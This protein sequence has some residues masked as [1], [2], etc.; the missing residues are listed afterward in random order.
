MLA[1][2][3][4]ERGAQK[5][6]RS[7]VLLLGRDDEAA[8]VLAPFDTPESLYALSSFMIYPKFD[9]R[10]YPVLLAHLARQGIRP[11][12]VTP[13]PYNCPPGSTSP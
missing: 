2:Y 11:R 1:W 13:E 8:R 7:E 4:G 9:A 3:H 10:R 5:P 6:V 12:P